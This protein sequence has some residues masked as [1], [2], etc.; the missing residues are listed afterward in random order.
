VHRTR[1]LLITIVFAVIA[2]AGIACRAAELAPEPYETAEPGAAAR[3]VR[4][5]TYCSPGGTDLA[6]DIHLPNAHTRPAPAVLYLHAGAWEF[7]D[8]NAYGGIATF[9]ELLGRGYVVAAIDYRLAPAHRFPAQI[10]DAKCA[11]RFL[12]GRAGE[13]GIDEDRIAALGGSAGGHLAALLGVTDSSHGFDGDGY[14]H[15]SSSVAAV[16]DLFG[17]ASL[18]TP[19]FIP[20]AADAAHRV[21][22][23][24]PGADP[25]RALNRASP[26]TYVSAGDPPFLIIHG[27]DDGVVPPNQSEALA[28]KLAAANVPVSLVMVDNAEH[29]LAA[30]GGAVTPSIDELVILI[31]DFLDWT[32]PPGAPDVSAHTAP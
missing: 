31:A 10:E 30:T 9:D 17:P 18:D 20:F 21:F 24:A 26:V 1:G 19:D 12:R 11:I 23:V 29:G 15:E 27:K 3:I 6:M 8:R 4:G 5:V 13:F 7:G 14:N 22:G 28:W 16:V 32:M 25:S 2:A